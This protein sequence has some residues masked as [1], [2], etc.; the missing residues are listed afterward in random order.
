MSNTTRNETRF[1]RGE[2]TDTDPDA[3]P[4]ICRNTAKRCRVLALAG[5]ATVGMA[6]LMASG[7]TTP[8][9]S[10]ATAPSCSPN[11]PKLTVQGVGLATGTPDTLTV[12]VSISVTDATAQAALAE[13]NTR[14]AAVIAAFIAGGVAKQNVQTTGLSVQPNYVLVHGNE[15]LTGYGVN[16]SVT[17]M[18]TNLASAGSVIDAVSGAAGNAGQI[19]SVS[20]SIKDTRDLEDQARTDAVHQAVSHAQTMA[21]SARERLGAVCSLTDSTPTSPTPSGFA[22]AQVN[23]ASP[24]PIEPGTQ[25]A[26]AQVTIVYSLEAN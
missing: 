18:I 5:A 13:D 15:V 2:R 14:A 7:C 10:A 25:Q 6:G 4:S 9:A 26:S 3:Q 12:D 16:N 11:S 17:A 1:D 19:N 24:V 8:N 20:F 22:G 21:I 23:A